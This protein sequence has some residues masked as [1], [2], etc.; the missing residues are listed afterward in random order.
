MGNILIYSSLENIYS[1][2]QPLSSKIIDEIDSFSEFIAAT[3]AF[4]TVQAI[5]NYDIMNVNTQAEYSFPVDFTEL[6]DRYGDNEYGVIEADIPIVVSCGIGM[7]NEGWYAVNGGYSFN[8]K[9]II[10]SIAFSPRIIPLIQSGDITQNFYHREVSTEIAQVF[11]HEFI[12]LIRD[13]YKID[14]AKG[15]SMVQDSDDFETSGILHDYEKVEI[16]PVLS[17]IHRLTER[18]NVAITNKNDELCEN[19][20]EKLKIV[21]SRYRHDREKVTILLKSR[22]LDDVYIEYILNYIIKR[23]YDIVDMVTDKEIKQELKNYIKGINR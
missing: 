4:D 17:Y 14:I 3:Q 20:K 18:L 10:L 8:D 22:G 21:M 16:E 6:N 7:L 23:L 12:H 13:L 15:Y 19:L 5:E 2:A 9:Y 11:Y 1:R